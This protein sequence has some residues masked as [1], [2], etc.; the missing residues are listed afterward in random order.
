MGERTNNINAR[1]RGMER[2]VERHGDRRERMNRKGERERERE[3]EIER[4]TQR[5]REEK[6]KPLF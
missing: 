2:N 4:G 6:S 3:I 1:D 5:E